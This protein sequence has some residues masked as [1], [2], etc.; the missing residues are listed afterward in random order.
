MAFAG[1][2]VVCHL[3]YLVGRGVPGPKGHFRGERRECRDVYFGVEVLR[4][5]N[6]VWKYRKKFMRPQWEEQLRVATS[7]KISKALSVQPS[8][9]EWR[10]RV[11]V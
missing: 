4:L 5:V 3:R 6:L 9:F 11:Y 10:G 2:A 7:W 8:K 1:G